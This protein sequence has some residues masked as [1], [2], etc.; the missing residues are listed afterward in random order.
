GD[1]STIKLTFYKWL[2]PKG[3][4]IHDEG[5]EPTVEAK[6]PDY[7]YTHPI[8]I[9]EP[10]VYNHTGEKIENVQQM[11][12]GLGYQI[13]RVD[14]YIDEVTQ[15]AENASHNDTDRK[16]TGE[17]DEKI[18]SLIEA[19]VIDKIRNGDDDQELEEALH[20]LYK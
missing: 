19:K 2:S 18:A 7:F 9:E 14:G 16:V 6:Q 10:L 4:W 3:V 17:I 1:G 15:E 5:V 13:D 12:K 11:L 8:Q 20:H